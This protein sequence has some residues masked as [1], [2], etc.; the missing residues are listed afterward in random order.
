MECFGGVLTEYV[1]T[2]GTQNTCS[3]VFYDA[4]GS[5]MD[6]PSNQTWTETFCA[7]NG[8]L[9][10]VD[11]NQLAVEIGVDDTL[12]IYGVSIINK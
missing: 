4:G 8:Q 6:Y 7:D 3:G 5:T 11:F 2:N 1:M 9:M 10:Q 12:S